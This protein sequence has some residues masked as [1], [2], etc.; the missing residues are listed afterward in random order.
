MGSSF[1]DQNLRDRLCLSPSLHPALGVEDG[2]WAGMWQ[3]GNLLQ[4]TGSPGGEPWGDR[5]QMP[6]EFQGD[7]DKWALWA[8]SACQWLK[9]R[10][11][12]QGTGAKQKPILKLILWKRRNERK[13]IWRKAVGTVAFKT[14]AAKDKFKLRSSKDIL[15]QPESHNW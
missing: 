15:L 13:E 2:G 11:L 1:R 12:I 6:L 10:H 4:Y 5:A 14:Q 8:V 7:N 9:L 3:C